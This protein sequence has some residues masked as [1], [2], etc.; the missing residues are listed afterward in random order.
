MMIGARG[1]VYL[2]GGILPRIQPILESSDF[3]AQFIE[4]GPM[5]GYTDGI[6]VWLS[7]SEEA[8]LLGAAA[9]AEKGGP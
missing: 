1:G 7:L 2:S 3:K 6:P 8:P 4:R 5:S 9:L